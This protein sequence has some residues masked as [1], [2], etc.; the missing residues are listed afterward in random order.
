[1]QITESGGLVFNDEKGNTQYIT[2]EELKELW[3]NKCKDGVVESVRSKFLNRSNTGIK[4]YNCTLDK[5]NKDNYLNHLQEE[6]MDG[7]A[8]IEKLLQQKEDI[9]QIIQ[10]T[11][12]DMDLGFKIRKLYGK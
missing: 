11:P 12:S 9:T 7:V 6:L 3:N 1:M 4:K 2:E 10:D 8:Y 5:N